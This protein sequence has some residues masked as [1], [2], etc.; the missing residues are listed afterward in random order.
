MTPTSGTTDG[1]KPGKTYV[2]HLVVDLTGARNI[3][4]AFLTA[5]PVVAQTP[6]WSDDELIRLAATHY[7]VPLSQVTLKPW[8][9]R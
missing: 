9:K 4:P 8:R 2:R 1:R 6:E 3:D 7:G 5:Y